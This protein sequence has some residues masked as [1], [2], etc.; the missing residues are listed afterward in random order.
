MGAG[1]TG[2]V[3]VVVGRSLKSR[4]KSSVEFEERAISSFTSC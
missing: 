4:E 1:S 2:E 3:G